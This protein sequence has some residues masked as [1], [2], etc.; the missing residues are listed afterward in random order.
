MIAG[1][2]GVKTLGRVRAFVRREGFRFDRDR[3]KWGAFD[4]T[5]VAKSFRQIPSASV[6]VSFIFRCYHGRKLAVQQDEEDGT[7]RRAT[8]N[9]F[10][11]G[12]NLGAKL[13]IIQRPTV[14]N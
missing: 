2:L 1:P 5:E 4:A 11:S 6:V 10:E 3:F 12:A 7:H 8:W 9:R 13:Q 14:D